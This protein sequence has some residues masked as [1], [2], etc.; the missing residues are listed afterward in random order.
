MEKP[1][2]DSLYRATLFVLRRCKESDPDRLDISFAEM[3]AV[4]G[5]DPLATFVDAV[6]FLQRLGVVYYD[7]IDQDKAAVRGVELTAIGKQLLNS[8][9]FGLV[10]HSTLGER[11]VA[12]SRSGSKRAMEETMSMVV[13]TIAGGGL[14]AAMV[15]TQG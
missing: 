7:D 13:R 9:P 14:A 12:V 4:D 1:Q 5:Q 2:K 3:D 11:I 10:T 6:E 8:Q 15:L